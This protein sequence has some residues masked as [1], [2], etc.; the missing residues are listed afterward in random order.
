MDYRK[1]VAA[2]IDEMAA[3]LLTEGVNEWNY[4]PEKKIKQHLRGIA[5][6]TTQAFLAQDGQ[7]IGFVSYNVG[8]IWPHYQ[9]I[10]LKHAQHGYLAE[11]VTHH[12]YRGRNI[13]PDLAQMAIDDMASSGIRRIYAMRHEE[14][15]ASARLMEKL[16]FEIIDTFDDPA[17]RQSGSRRTTVCR[18]VK[19]LNN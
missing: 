11:A 14:N 16:G 17:K 10:N 9:P 6:G 8:I 3:L 1:A 19:G 4:L 2:D 5:D 15:R 18:L 7:V 13:G 12:D